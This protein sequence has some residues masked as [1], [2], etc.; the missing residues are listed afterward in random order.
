MNGFICLLVVNILNW[1][2]FG[3]QTKGLEKQECNKLGHTYIFMYHNNWEYYKTMSMKWEY[4]SDGTSFHC[5]ASCMGGRKLENKKE[6]YTDM[7]RM[8]NSAHSNPCSGGKRG[9]MKLWSNSDTY[10]ITLLSI[11]STLIPSITTLYGPGLWWI[12]SL[13]LE[14]WAWGRNA[15]WMGLRYGQWFKIHRKY[16][17]TEELIKCYIFQYI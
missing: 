14:H 5:M 3:F 1:R 7:G 10:C 12:W 8:Q 11:W 16:T 2:I 4:A 17:Y 6:L 15:H 9:T 13:S